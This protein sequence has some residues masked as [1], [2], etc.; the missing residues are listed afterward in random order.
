MIYGT[1]DRD[2]RNI[3]LKELYQICINPNETELHNYLLH[4]LYEL[5]HWALWG[6]LNPSS[7]PLRRTE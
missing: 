3:A 2:L 7:L 4:N 5:E 1:D 6:R